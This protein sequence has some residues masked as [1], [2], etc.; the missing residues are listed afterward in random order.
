MTVDLEVSFEGARKVKGKPY[1]VKL[2][3]KVSPVDY[4]K[5]SVKQINHNHRPVSS[6]RATQY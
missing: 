6:L 2:K 3:L 4:N 1:V 5:F